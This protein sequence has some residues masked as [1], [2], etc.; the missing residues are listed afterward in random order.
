MRKALG[1]WSFL[2]VHSPLVGPSTWVPTADLL[3][4]RGHDGAVPDLTGV[5]DASVP[6]WGWLV[7]QAAAATDD[8]NGPVTVVGHSGAG[9]FLPAIGAA[10]E[11]RLGGL[12]FVDAVLPAT[13]GAHRAP[14]R[15]LELL[16]QQTSD[17]VLRRWLEWW[18]DDVARELVPDDELRSAL[19]SEMPRLPRDLYDE[20]VPLPGGWTDGRCAYVRLSAGYAEQHDEARRRGWVTA[21]LDADHL[22]ICTQPELVAAALL[23]VVGA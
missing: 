23:E 21:A 15:Q 9:A 8:L 14:P 20:V 18:P 11:E 16:D 2:L 4:A 7:R 3:R 1:D 17:G 6:R 12:V 13:D 5:A 22:A 19:L 10:L